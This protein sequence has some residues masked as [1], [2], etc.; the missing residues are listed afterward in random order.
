[1]LPSLP[2]NA[3]H[4]WPSGHIFHSPGAHLTY[5]V[6][7]PCCRLYDRDQLPWPCCRLQWRGKEPSW[8]RI[9]R[10]FIVDLSTRRHPSYCVELVGQGYRGE[11][12]V[13]TLYTAKLSSE[14]QN[15][16]HTK[17]QP[18][19]HIIPLEDTEAVP[20][21]AASARSAIPGTAASRVIEPNS[22]AV[23]D[24]NEQTAAVNIPA[25]ED[26]SAAP[27]DSQKPR[28]KSTKQPPE[29]PAYPQLSL[30]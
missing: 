1:M 22:A 30:L 16:W 9:G 11:A 3:E 25:E 18:V 2:A 8:R 10:R 28:A 14:L 29:P 19:G 5:R 21:Y 26:A 7:G 15:W 12:F 20:A 6:V 4:P 17:R 27:P 13:T 23:A 24:R